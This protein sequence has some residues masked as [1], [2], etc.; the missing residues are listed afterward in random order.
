MLAIPLL[1][2]NTSREIYRDPAAKELLESLLA[3][4]SYGPK[5]TCELMQIVC[6]LLEHM[7][8]ED[9]AE[10]RKD[11]L[12]F[13]WSILKEN[14]VATKYHAFLAVTRFISVFE[15]PSKVILQV[16]HSLLKD[17]SERSMVRM[18]MDVLL[19]ALPM[20][21]G[22]DD[23]E[24]A[25][26][27]TLKVMRED[28][29]SLP[30]MAHLW[31]TITLHPEVYVRHKCDFLPSLIQSL[32]V[33]RDHEPNTS[34]EVIELVADLAQLIFDW[35]VS[36]EIARPNQA[37]FDD[38]VDTLV[39]FA[40]LNAASKPDQRR[41]HLQAKILS[42]FKD[43]VSSQVGCK[44]SPVLFDSVISYE[45]GSEGYQ[46]ETDEKSRRKESI[47]SLSHDAD[48]IYS[49]NLLLCAE[50]MHILLSTD[51]SNDLLQL[52]VGAIVSKCLNALTAENSRLKQI[53][54][55][56]LHHLLVVGHTN[57]TVSCIVVMLEGHIRPTGDQVY[58]SHFAISV[59][60]KACAAKPDI[61]ERFVGC[62]AKFAAGAA[63]EHVRGANERQK[64][65]SSMQQMAENG[66][67]HEIS[68][69]PTLGIFELACGLGFKPLSLGKDVQVSDGGFKRQLVVD[70]ER[71]SMSIRALISSLRLLGSHDI[72]HTFS[73]TRRAF[74]KM[75]ST[76]LD[77]S[78]SIPGA[79]CE[80]D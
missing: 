17:A 6:L 74:M 2:Q 4:T 10:Y 42:L 33:L 29:H 67:Q 44:I 15:T 45:V 64:S 9:I 16:Y 77:C 48:A 24:T 5:L 36:D 66:R 69:T 37:E 27:H 54:G 78:D 31:E 3:E 14:D 28:G 41:R 61:I 71:L 12:K 76:L 32:S 58:G 79:S 30:L 68:A 40:F 38:V 60:E 70:N 55:S 43:F 53:I 19:P 63:E 80:I 7:P 8:V 56:I 75:L 39:R 50:I 26:K 34:L 1:I 73:G 18:A 49:N 57:E 62:L 51:P 25:L 59:I 13:I 46:T 11:L 47:D 21:L 72:F 35:A 52:K 20:R 23:L 22:S 65:A